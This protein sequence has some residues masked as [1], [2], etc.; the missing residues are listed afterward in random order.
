MSGA[1]R[2][3]VFGAGAFG[4]WSALELARQ[5][6]AV[7]L[8]EAWG[9]GHDRSS[10]GGETRIIRAT[11]GS[12][13]IYTTLSLRALELW[14]AHD[15]GSRAPLLH[16]TGVLWMFGDDDSFGRASAQVLA[17]HRASLE[18]LTLAAAR[19]RYPQ[20]D[21][22]GLSSILYE[23]E[24][25][26]LYARRA[27]RDVVAR[28]A[29]EGG[30]YRLGA[31][32]APVG[33]DGDRVKQLRLGDGTVVEADAF[34]FACGPWLATLFPDL[35]GSILT[36][37]RQEVYYF[38]PPAGDPAFTDRRL[39]V[40]IDMSERQIYGIPAIASSGFKVADDT[41]GPA[42]DPTTSD[43][44]PT[45]AGVAAARAFLARRFP[46]LAGAPLVASE[47]CQYE[48]SRDAGFIIDR[49]PAASNVWIVGGGSGHGFKMG[50]AVGELVA[51]AVLERAAPDPNFSLA[52]FA[53][54]P[55]GGWQTRWS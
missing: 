37:T 32:T 17:G 3:V 25:G 24:A 48:S 26:Y 35:L 9:P 20:I 11:Y 47:V 46:A 52:R 30:E 4:G 16:K 21:F 1:V 45:A 23:P 42:I 7:T 39:P 31:A 34:V 15:A 41:S 6:A 5:G 10:S 33:L 22:A 54:S 28:V 40:W 14:R 49:H 27:C 8:I 13:A 53:A 19:Q 29:A 55:T 51:R 36:A 44:T 18:P 43:R 12:R 38:G 50:P 2:V